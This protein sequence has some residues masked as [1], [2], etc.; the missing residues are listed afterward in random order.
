MSF[1]GTCRDGIVSNGICRR[2]NEDL[3]ILRDAIQAIY[4]LIEHSSIFH[5]TDSDLLRNSEKVLHTHIL[6]Q[7]AKDIIVDRE[8]LVF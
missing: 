8:H 2:P 3:L 1:A 5:L 7:S 4:T 6:R